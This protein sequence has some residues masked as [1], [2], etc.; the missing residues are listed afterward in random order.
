MFTGRS[1]GGTVVMSTS[2]MS[3]RPPLGNGKT[4][5]HAQ[6]RGLAAA[7]GADQANISPL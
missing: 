4:G 7:R 5:Q 6:Q 2:S 1:C 3:M